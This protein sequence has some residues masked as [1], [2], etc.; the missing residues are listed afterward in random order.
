MISDLYKND[1]ERHFF[2]LAPRA[3]DEG[4]LAHKLG[5][6]LAALQTWVVILA[7]WWG[8]R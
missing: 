1:L 8:W 7:T 4:R 3:A 6:L 2:A 5:S